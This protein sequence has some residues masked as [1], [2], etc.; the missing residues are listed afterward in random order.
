MP[1]LKRA[2]EQTQSDWRLLPEGVARFIIGK[3]EL[4]LDEK[5][6]NYRVRFPLSLPP[7]EQDRIFEELGK[8]EDGI[9]QSYRANYRVGLSLGYVDKTGTYKTTKLVD[10]LASAFGST[11]SKKFRE[12]IANGGGP[13]RPADLDDQQGELACISDWLDW[14]EGLELYGTIRHQDSADGSTTYANFAGPMAIGSLPGQKDDDYQAHGRGKLRA[15]IA[16]SGDQ[17]EDKHREER[18]E[19][20]GF[21]RFTPDGKAVRTSGPDDELPF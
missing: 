19:A 16:E 20:Q 6:G 21:E 18:L 9:Q 4:F 1:L 13:P 17:R 14:W 11:N 3:P 10:M 7:S 5:Y 12:W 8:P 15:L 2:S